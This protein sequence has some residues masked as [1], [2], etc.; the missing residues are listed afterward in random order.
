M[1]KLTRDQSVTLIINTAGVGDRPET[2]IALSRRFFGGRELEKIAAGIVS[3]DR[4]MGWFSY[5]SI[6]CAVRK[7]QTSEKD[8]LKVI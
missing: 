7:N 5:P 2:Q 3:E 4:G 6:D 1:E 8:L